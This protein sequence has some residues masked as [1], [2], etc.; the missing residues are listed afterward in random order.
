M[1]KE[2]MIGFAS[3]LHEGKKERS[4]QQHFDLSK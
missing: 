3:G 1:L 4:Q 2:L